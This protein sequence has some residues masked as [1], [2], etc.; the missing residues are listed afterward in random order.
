MWQKH[1][2]SDT[3]KALTRTD[4]PNTCKHYRHIRPTHRTTAS[5]ART[6]GSIAGSDAR[7]HTVWATRAHHTTL[8]RCSKTLLVTALGDLSTQGNETQNVSSD[9]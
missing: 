7:K 8:A 4:T 6:G 1:R 3:Y 5:G 9:G 2:T